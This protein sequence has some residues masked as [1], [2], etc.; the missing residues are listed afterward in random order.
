MMQ[1]FNWC[2]IGHYVNVYD[3]SGRLR[4]NQPS[5]AVALPKPRR[6]RTETYHSSIFTSIADIWSNCTSLCSFKNTLKYFIGKS[7]LHSLP[8]IYVI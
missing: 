1:V 3:D 7:C 4:V 2:D 5:A 6:T 8:M